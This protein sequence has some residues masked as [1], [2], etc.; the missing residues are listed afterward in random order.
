MEW[1]CAVLPTILE[2]ED[3]L[4]KTLHK[5][6]LIWWNNPIFKL[7]V[8]TNLIFLLGALDECSGAL[9]V[10]GAVVGKQGPCVIYWLKELEV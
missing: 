6:S 10:S 1:S 8:L 5:S 2:N 9:V 3:H 7:K 4:L